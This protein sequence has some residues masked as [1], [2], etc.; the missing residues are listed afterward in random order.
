M[1][2]EIDYC[3]KLCTRAVR[4]PN[5][6]RIRKLWVWQGIEPHIFSY[7]G[8]C[9]NLWATDHTHG[10]LTLLLMLISI[11]EFEFQW[12]L[13]TILYHEYLTF[14][15]NLTAGL[16]PSIEHIREFWT[17]INC[18]IL[19]LVITLTNYESHLQEERPFYMWG[20]FHRESSSPVPLISIRA[21][22]YER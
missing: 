21:A 18:Q 2:F 10:M 9:S 13:T 6:K 12:I 20:C 3:V 8:R 15:I 17:R 14:L 11:F 4:T 1:S 5:A 19:M 7:R 16:S 22:P